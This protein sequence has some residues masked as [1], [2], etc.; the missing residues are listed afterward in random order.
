MHEAAGIPAASLRFGPCLMF[1][2]ETLFGKGL[3]REWRKP[4]ITR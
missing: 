3:P 2:I 1:L 4:R